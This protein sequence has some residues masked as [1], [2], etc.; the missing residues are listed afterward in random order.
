[1]GVHGGSLYVPTSLI[2][3]ADDPT[4]RAWVRNV[5]DDPN[6]RLRID[7]T[8]YPLR[9]VKVED[10]NEVATVRAMLLEKY[11]VEVDEHVEQGW[12]F[13]MDPR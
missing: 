2:L 8:V 10:P 1:M 13:R 3:G 7:G 4:E 6:V 9:A 11:D 12:I 5:L